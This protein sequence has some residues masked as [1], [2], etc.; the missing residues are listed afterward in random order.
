M[1]NQLMGV[2]LPKGLNYL[3]NYTKI[4]FHLVIDEFVLIFTFLNHTLF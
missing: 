3:I 1:S 2:E 4:L